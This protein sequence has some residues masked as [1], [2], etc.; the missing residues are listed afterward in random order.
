MKAGEVSLH[1][2]DDT[3]SFVYIDDVVTATLLAGE[4]PA[5]AGEIVNVGSEDEIRILDLARVILRLAGRDDEIE[6]HPAPRGSVARRAPDTAKLRALTG[7]SP[8][9]SLEEGLE[10]TMAYYL[11]T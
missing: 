9:W 7:F 11:G 10:R 2:A 1:G 8:A 6:I 3:R 5:T 4:A